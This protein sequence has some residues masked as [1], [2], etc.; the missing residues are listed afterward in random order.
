MDNILNQQL[1]TGATTVSVIGM[2]FAF[3]FPYI[4]QL[5]VKVFKRELSKDEKRALSHMI[6][7]AVSITITGIFWD[8]K[9]ISWDEII[10]FAVA[11]G[12]SFMSGTGT[13]WTVYTMIIKNIPALDKA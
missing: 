5:W 2:A 9:G 13:V 12:G 7:L 6:I 3:V 1:V 8:W 11:L 4:C 10:R